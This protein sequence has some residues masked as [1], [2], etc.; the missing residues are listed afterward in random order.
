VARR[1]CSANCTLVYDSDTIG[2]KEPC[3]QRY[4]AFPEHLPLSMIRHARAVT[5]RDEMLILHYGRVSLSIPC[6][7]YDAFQPQHVRSYLVEDRGT[8]TIE[9]LIRRGPYVVESGNK[10]EVSATAALE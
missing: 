7:G 2:P 10:R 3:V 1:K 5:T 8:V 4:L 9:T 6:N